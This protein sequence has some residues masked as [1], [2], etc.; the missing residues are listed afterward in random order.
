MH[1][2]ERKHFLPV[3]FL[4]LIMKPKMWKISRKLKLHIQADSITGVSHFVIKKF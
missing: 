3:L 1:G 4:L 2:Y